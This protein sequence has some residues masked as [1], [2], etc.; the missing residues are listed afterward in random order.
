MIILLLFISSFYFSLVIM[1]TL[2]DGIDWNLNFETVFFS[3][4]ISFF[5]AIITTFF[6]I[7]FF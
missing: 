7:L 1:F 4:L 3:S 6:F 2:S 5:F